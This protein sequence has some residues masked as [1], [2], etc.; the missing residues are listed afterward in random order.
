MSRFPI[1]HRIKEVL[2][3]TA[4]P[5]FVWAAFLCGTAWA[6]GDVDVHIDVVLPL[7]IEVEAPPTM[8]YLAEPGVYVAVGIGY[9]L[10]FIGGRYY[11]YHGNKWF[12]ASGY[13]EPWVHVVVKS[14]PPGLRKFNMTKL[15]QFRAREFKAFKA[16]GL[17][18]KGK[19]FKA[20]AGPGPKAKKAMKHKGKRK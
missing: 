17:K 10:F 12:W 13:G 5:V 18:Y 6:G 7:P 4:L 15:H 3:K 2:V 19:Q 20:V 9:D 16:Q 14:L 8:V 1:N 11:Y